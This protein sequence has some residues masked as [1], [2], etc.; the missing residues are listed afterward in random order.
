MLPSENLTTPRLVLRELKDEDLQAIFA[1]RSNETVCRYIDRPV[2]QHISEASAFIERIRKGYADNST[3]YW[4]LSLKGEQELLGTICLWN[5]SGDGVAEIGY[6]MLPQHHGKGYMQESL[7]AISEYSF[8][9]L[10]LSAID[11]FTHRDNTASKKLLERNGFNLCEGR[12]DPDVPANVIYRK[13]A[14][15]NIK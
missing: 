14:P 7:A 5:F 6:E 3:Y 12:T 15:L 4:V 8:N 9:I 11:A 1:L 13:G 10:K 2:P